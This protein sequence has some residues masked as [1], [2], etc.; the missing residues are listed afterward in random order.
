M[1]FM[2]PMTGEV[3]ILESLCWDVPVEQWRYVQ[4]TELSKMVDGVS[5]SQMG[6]IIRRLQKRDPRIKVVN[7]H[8]NITKY[9]M[10]SAVSHD[11]V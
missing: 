11:T 2:M 3:E 7:A 1:E 6:K 9:L 5:P 10:P 8:N 4:A